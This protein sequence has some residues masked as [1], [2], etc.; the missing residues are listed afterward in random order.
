MTTLQLKASEALLITTPEHIAY[1][2]DFD[3]EG[4]VVITKKEIM[5]A[6]DQRYW[7]LA[8]SVK[9]KSVKLF[10]IKGSWPEK[11]REHLKSTKTLYFEDEHITISEL[12]RWKRILPKRKWKSSESAIR[13]QRLIKNGDELDKLR[14]AAKIGD[15]VLNKV[16]KHLKPGVTEKQIANLFRQYSNE[17]ANGVSFDPIVAFGVNGAVP[18]HHSGNQK[19]KKNDA[20][21]IDQGVNY[22]GYMSD[23]TRCF[24]IGKGIQAVQEMYEN[25]A[26]AQQAGVNMVR[27]GVK[28]SDLAVAVRAMLGKE[29]KYFTHSLGHGVGMEV[30]EAPGVSTRSDVILEPGMVITIEPGIYKAKIGGVRIEDTLVVTEGGCE[31]ITKSTKKTAVRQ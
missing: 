14:M 30:H 29:E 5:L 28:I 15:K 10:D 22:Q 7:L 25:L 11:L 27:P 20:I 21:L 9:K 23:M 13:K 6:T 26:K 31:V 16:L 8:K 1:L 12:K 24:F 19:L 2:T 18:H 4:F 17:L 3:G